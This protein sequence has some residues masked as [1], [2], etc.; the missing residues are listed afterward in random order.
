MELL[1]FLTNPLDLPK[2]KCIFGVFYYSVVKIMFSV[3]M[4]ERMALTLNDLDEETKALEKNL[5]AQFNKDDEV[6]TSI[7]TFHFGVKLM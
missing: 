1:H 7:C 2:L 5:I 3:H 6:N 4:K